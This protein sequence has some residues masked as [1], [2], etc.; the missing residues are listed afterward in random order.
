MITRDCRPNA[1]S[2]QSRRCPTLQPS[3][4]SIT[5]ACFSCLCL[6]TLQALGQPA[7]NEFPIVIE[8]V[9][10]SVKA[11]KPTAPIVFEL[12]VDKDSLPQSELIIAIMLSHSDISSYMS[13]EE[14]SVF[15][16][17]KLGVDKIQKFRAV[18]KEA[19]N[20]TFPSTDTKPWIGVKYSINQAFEVESEKGK[21]L[22]YQLISQGGKDVGGA[23]TSSLRNVAGKWSI[24]ADESEDFQLYLSKLVPAEFAK[25]HQASQIEALPFEDLL[26]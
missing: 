2:Y 7:K 15:F 10:C 26:K 22:V 12:I 16:G 1:Q 4:K 21:F 14:I 13:D 18:M 11:Y 3:M 8:G 5:F 20:F 17:P 6:L 24:G 19:V 9:K 23:V 25:L